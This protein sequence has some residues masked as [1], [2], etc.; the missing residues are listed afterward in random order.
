M[1]K[2]QEEFTLP[3]YYRQQSRTMNKK[4]IY[5]LPKPTQPKSYQNLKWDNTAHH[6]AFIFFIIQ[7][8]SNHDLTPKLELH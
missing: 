7:W 5:Y 6:R 3:I 2:N 1:K 8:T 4:Y